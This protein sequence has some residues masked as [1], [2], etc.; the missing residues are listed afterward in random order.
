MDDTERLVG[1]PDVVVEAAM[2]IQTNLLLREIAYQL[3]LLNERGENVSQM[4]A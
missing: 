4:P 2:K 1:K 3:A